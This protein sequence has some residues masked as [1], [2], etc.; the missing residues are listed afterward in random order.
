MKTNRKKII[1][2]AVLTLAMSFVVMMG[3]AQQ[4]Y[5]QSGSPVFT[6][7]GTSTMHDWTMT[8]QGATYNASI[9]VNADGTPSKLTLVT[10]TLPAESLKSHEKAMDKNA[11]KSLNTD[12]YKDITF[13]LTSSKIAGKTIT[14]NGNLT[15]AGTTKAI[16]VDVT[17][18]V[19]NSTLVCKG[20][21]KLKMTDFKVE[22]PTFMFGAIKTGDDITVTFEVTLAPN[23]L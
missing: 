17:Y 4:S 14:C 21:K 19:K 8:S 3:I 15:I 11:Y 23:K 6:I 9:E 2:R 10:V 5:R 16:D 18:E 7:A 12:K 20:S 22:P 13:Q 1:T